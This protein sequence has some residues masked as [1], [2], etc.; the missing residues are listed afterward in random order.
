MMIKKL[1][2]LTAIITG[3]SFVTDSGNCSNNTNTKVEEKNSHQNTLSEVLKKRHQ[4]LHMY[5]DDNDD[6]YYSDM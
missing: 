3:F 1:L 5:D 4:Q 6:E 2:M